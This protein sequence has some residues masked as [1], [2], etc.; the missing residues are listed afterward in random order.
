M[1][2]ITIISFQTFNYN[3]PNLHRFKKKLYVKQKHFNFFGRS[4]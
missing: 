1:W 2:A 3:K 4:E